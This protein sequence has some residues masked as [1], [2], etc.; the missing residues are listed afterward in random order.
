MS[1]ADIRKELFEGEN[2][3]TDKKNDHGLSNVAKVRMLPD[4]KL[5]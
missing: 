2:I 3:V 1:V 4:T 5:N